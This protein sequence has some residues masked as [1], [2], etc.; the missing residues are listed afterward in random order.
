MFTVKIC[1]RYLRE[2]KILVYVASIVMG[3]GV[4]GTGFESRKG[5]AFHLP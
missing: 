2:C 3:Y 1:A 5:R 4:D